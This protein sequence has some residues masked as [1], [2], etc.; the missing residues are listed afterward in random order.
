MEPTAIKNT[1]NVQDFFLNLGATISLYVVAGSLINLLFTVINKSYPKITNGYEYFGS[2]SISWPVAVL[3]I[4]FPIFILFMWLL[5]KD[6]TL[7]PDKRSSGIHKWLTYITLFLAG[8]LLA[9]DLIAVLYYFIDGQELTTGFLLKVLVLLVI[10][11]GVFTYYISDVK[12]KL[13]VKSRMYWR[14]F[15]AALVL[16]SIIWG[17]AVLGSPRT[18]RLVKYDEQKVND[19]SNIRYAIESYYSANGSVP[20][21][22]DS[23]TTNYY[24]FSKVDVQT[25]KPYEYS[26]T[27]ETSYKICADFNRK[28][29]NER[30]GNSL[31]YPMY[32]GD[33]F[34]TWDHEAGRH[35]F[36][37]KINPNL[38][39]KPIPA[40]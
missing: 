27:G 34:T 36:D 9:G 23:L 14:V 33:G 29:T 20:D 7:N 22:L 28:S 6:Y 8:G 18:Q 25:N 15:A 3:I 30:G 17:F 16:G 31:A 39:S 19:I 35:C 12:G 26:K 2:T 24:Y 11:T 13:T 38:Y 4:F 21:T 10:S 32:G 5:A 37:Q 40:R 1:S